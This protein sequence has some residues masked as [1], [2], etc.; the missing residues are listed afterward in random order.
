MIKARKRVLGIEHSDT[1]TSMA[2]LAYALNSQGQYQEAIE[3]LGSVT[4]LRRKVLGSSHP[5][6]ITSLNMLKPWQRQVWYQ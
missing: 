4:E 3:M 1:L 2:N 6:T 5:S